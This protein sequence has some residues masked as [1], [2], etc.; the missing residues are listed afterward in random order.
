MRFDILLDQPRH[1][2]VHA[3]DNAEDID[4]ETPMQALSEVSQILAAPPA[5]MPALLRPDG[6][7]EM[8]K[9]A[10]GQRFDRLRIGNIGDLGDGFDTGLAQLGQRGLQRAMLDIGKHDLGPGPAEPERQ[11][12]ADTARR[13]GDDATLLVKSFMRSSS[14]LSFLTLA[15]LAG[16][17]GEQERAG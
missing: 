10:L 16:E 13:A 7:A 1:E 8:G 2:A 12:P 17:G 9:A 3:V 5:P 14:L 6:P 4:V 11:R 15:R